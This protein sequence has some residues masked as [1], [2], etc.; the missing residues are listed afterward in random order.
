MDRNNFE[1]EFGR[2]STRHTPFDPNPFEEGPSRKKPFLKDDAFISISKLPV[3]PA[4]EMP[5]SAPEMIILNQC[6]TQ[7]PH[8]QNEVVSNEQLRKSRSTIVNGSNS[9]CEYDYAEFL[10]DLCS[11]GVYNGRCYLR[12]STGMYVPI[13]R[14]NVGTI[15]VDILPDQQKRSLR[16]AMYNGIAQQ[17]RYLTLNSEK[18]LAIKPNLVKLRSG[19]WDLEK[20]HF[21]EAPSG[22]YIPFAIDAD[23]VDDSDIQCESFCYFLKSVSGKDQDIMRQIAYFLA[24]SAL[25]P[26][27]DAKKIHLLGFAQNSGKSTLIRILNRMIDR[28]AFMPPNALGRKFATGALMDTA[29]CFCA[30]LPKEHLRSNAVGVC[31]AISGRDGLSAELKRQNMSFMDPNIKL[32][33]AS[34]H[35]IVLEAQ[36]DPFLSRIEPVPFQCS[37][38]PKKV[39]FKLEGRIWQER[40]SWITMLLPVAQSLIKDYRFP[41]SKAA[42]AMKQEMF[43][44]NNRKTAQDSLAEFASA[45]CRRVDGACVPTKVVRSAY[46]KWCNTTGTSIIP[47]NQFPGAIAALLDGVCSKVIQYQGIQCTRFRGLAL[48]NP[49]TGEL[50]MS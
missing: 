30:E 26:R 46:V 11:P 48:Q 43:A 21:C 45:Y 1:P 5:K 8:E 35:Q 36:D 39:D 24:Y 14:D 22:C 25:V 18:T 20:A 17:L 27:A 41:S 28:T 47:E 23:V 3:E 37:I 13:H 32:V 15:L 44:L 38:D 12:N 16:Y 9:W 2:V 50:I 34:N 40:D 42:A 29:V 7:P 31:K 6:D 4:V 10:F 49:E 33:W 19:I